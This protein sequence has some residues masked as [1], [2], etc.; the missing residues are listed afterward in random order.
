MAIRSKRYIILVL[1]SIL[2]TLSACTSTKLEVYEGR[3]LKIAVI[4]EPPQVREERITFKKISFDDL[5]EDNLE[6]YDAVIVT[7]E[8]LNQAAESQYAEIYSNPPI[9]FF[10][11]S[12]TNHIPFI[13]KEIEYDDSWDWSPGNNYAVGVLKSNEEDTLTHWG[14]GLYNDIKNDEHIKE[15][16][17]RIFKTVAELD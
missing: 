11:I 10:F 4:G 8:N 15:V 5:N 16:Y 12:T 2:F 13:I 3:S 9:P 6:G 1:L 7:Q 14:Y 17:S